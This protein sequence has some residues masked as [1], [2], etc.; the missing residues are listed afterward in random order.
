MQCT[1]NVGVRRVR[2][3]INAVEKKYFECVC[4]FI[5]VLVFRNA[6]RI[7]S[8]TSYYIVICDMSGCTIF[9]TL[10]HKRNDLKKGK[11]SKCFDFPHNFC[12]KTLN[13]LRIIPQDTVLNVHRPSR[14]V[15][16]IINK[17]EQWYVRH[18]WFYC[19]FITG[20]MFR[21]TYRSSSGLL[22]GE[23]VSAMLLR[24]LLLKGL[25]MTC[26]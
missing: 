23:S 7:F 26:M 25:K 4:A 15:P 11:Q 5:L 2:V 10:S 19:C 8:N 17:V 24:T 16:V 12:L 1:Y 9:S 13:I 3:T 6:N 14:K 22:T 21:P 18:N 20:Y